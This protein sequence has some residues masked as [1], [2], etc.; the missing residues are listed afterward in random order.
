M[1]SDVIR[2]QTPGDWSCG[3]GDEPDEG[4]SAVAGPFPV[5]GKMKAAV[6]GA[7]V[8]GA[9]LLG[10]HFLQNKGRGGGRSKVSNPVLYETP[11]K[12]P[13]GRIIM[14]PRMAEVVRARALAGRKAA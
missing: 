9:A 11:Y 4:S 3:I 12:S 14:S 13:S 6:V 10:W 5:S 8:A 1:A 7:A 2:G